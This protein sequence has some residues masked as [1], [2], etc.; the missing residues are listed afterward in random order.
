MTHVTD[1]PSYFRVGLLLWQGECV[2]VCGKGGGGGGGGGVQ[3]YM[4]ASMPVK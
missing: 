1:S 4:I 2:C 3:F